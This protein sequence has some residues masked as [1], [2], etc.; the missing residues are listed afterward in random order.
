[1]RSC[2]SKLLELASNPNTHSGKFARIVF[3]YGLALVRVMPFI[4]KPFNWIVKHFP[5]LERKAHQFVHLIK[6][7]KKYQSAYLEQVEKIQKILNKPLK[8]DNIVNDLYAKFDLSQ[9]GTIYYWVEHTI[10]F[11]KNTGIQRVVRQL[12]RA[13]IEIGVELIPMQWDRRKLCFK[14]ISNEDLDHLAKWNGPCKEG[15]ADWRDPEYAGEN[16]WLFVPELNYYF[17]EE[18]VEVLHKYTKARNLKTALIYY[19]TLPITLSHIDKSNTIH[20]LEYMLGLCYFDLIIPISGT[21]ATEL[22]RYFAGTCDSVTSLE[23]KICAC[24][25]PG[26]FSQ[27]SRILQIKEKMVS[28]WRILCVSTL[29]LRKNHIAL[30]QAFESLSQQSMFDMELILVGRPASEEVV[31][32]V[33]KYTKLY[34]NIR[35]VQDADDRDLHHFYNQCD[36]TVYPSLSEGFGLP[37]LESLWYARPCICR[38]TGA[39]AEVAM[40]GGCLTVDTTDAIALAS[41]IKT[42]MENESLY[43]KLAKEAIERHFKTW[44]GYGTDVISQ[45][46]SCSG[47]FGI[48]E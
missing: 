47:A 26:E 29:E 28:T 30:L 2:L 35:W 45:L 40:G 34:P 8:E 18:E 10:H 19:D 33:K 23:T 6:L 13:L 46:V 43:R 41:A 42:L 21:S 1:M 4:K 20:H 39:L 36:F 24:D 27:S 38:N 9:I 44:Q 37:V 14:R 22:Q 3:S 12:A 32:Q 48:F 7:E 11:H 16:A 15:W 5:G 31:A 17:S 25:L